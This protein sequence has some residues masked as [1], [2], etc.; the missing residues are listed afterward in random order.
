M[1]WQSLNK[2][3]RYNSKVN[4]FVNEMEEEQKEEIVYLMI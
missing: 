2:V 1:I 3:L 4:E